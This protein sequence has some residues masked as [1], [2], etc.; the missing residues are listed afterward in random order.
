MY[1]TKIVHCLLADRSA[2]YHI[3][4]LATDRISETLKFQRVQLFLL[5]SLCEYV[6]IYTY[7]YMHKAQY[8]YS[9]QQPIRKKLIFRRERYVYH[10]VS[11]LGT[12][13]EPWT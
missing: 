10:N 12:L 13:L 7:M 9:L 2:V 11:Q 1:K 5:R 3:F 8:K 4:P 6:L